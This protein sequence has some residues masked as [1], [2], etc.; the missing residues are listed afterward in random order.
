[1]DRS[2]EIRDQVLAA[3]ENAAP[4]AI[5]GGGSKAFYADPGAGEPLE[6]T[7]HQGIVNYDP[8]ELVMTC[9]AGT[10]LEEVRTVLAENGQHLPFEPPAFG[11]IATIGG[12]VACGFSGPCRPWAGALR[13]YLLGV[14]IINGRGEILSFGGQVMKNVAGYDVSRL[15]AGARGTLGVLLETSFKVLPL[16]A[17][18]LTLEFNTSHNRAVTRMN[19]W[20]GQPL[21]LSAAA[22]QEGIMRIRLSGAASEVD[23]AAGKLKPE[24]VLDSNAW[25]RDLREHSLPFFSSDLPL[26]RISVPP[27][28][29]PWEV[30]GEFL[31]DWGG[32]QHWYKTQEPAEEIHRH[33]GAAGGH[34]V[35][36]RGP[37]DVA[38]FHPLP[39]AAARLQERVRAA[40]DPQGIF[41]PEM[42][43]GGGG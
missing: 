7:G 8:G 29:T 40:F 33:A 39:G 37:P 41:N 5:R 28:S 1:M 30:L 15:M 18:E 34:A 20:S 14:K 10:R 17:K 24:N 13:D 11:E 4:L 36:F 43:G 6:M 9:R 23:S 25:W 31:V 2:T 16:P 26:W 27:A 42:A 22:W 19:E 38:K 12:T 3:L 21:P 35:L 32:A